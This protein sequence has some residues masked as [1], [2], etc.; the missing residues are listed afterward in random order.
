[1][2]PLAEVVEG[3]PSELSALVASMLAKDPEA[4]A[5]LNEASDPAPNGQP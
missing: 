2:P 1:M 3:V 4:R 5:A